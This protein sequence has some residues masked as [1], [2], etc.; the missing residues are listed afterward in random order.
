VLALLSNLTLQSCLPQEPTYQLYEK[1]KV[2]S[3]EVQG[4]HSTTRLLYSPQYL[5]L[6]R[7]TVLNPAYSSNTAT[8][9]QIARTLL[10]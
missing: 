3:D 4:H 8:W 5:D 10:L 9:S 1:A 6:L 7:F 2:C